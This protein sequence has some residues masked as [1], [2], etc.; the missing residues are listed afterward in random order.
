MSTT[1]HPEGM[2][3]HHHPAP[4]GP[5]PVYVP[6]AMPYYPPPPRRRGF[7]G[8]LFLSLFMLIFIGSLFMNFMMAGLVASFMGEG[9][10][11]E[12]FFSHDAFAKDKVAIIPI[13]GVI[14]ETEDGF[15][16]RAIDAAMKDENVKG[17]VLRVDS[18][19]GSVTGSDF[20]YHHLRKLAEDRN[21]PIVV[22]MGGIAASGGYYVSMAVGDEPNTIFAEPTGWTG[23]IGV[24]MP[25]YDISG[26]LSKYDIVDDS[27]PSHPLKE[28]GSIT[29]PMTAEERKIIKALVDDSFTRFKDVVK[30]G[31][32]KFKKD[33]SALD[34]LAT[35]Q[36][37]TAD[38]AAKNG[39]IDKLGFVEDA[40][41]RAIELARLDKKKVRVV[42]YKPE[43]SLSSMLLGSETR[44]SMGS[45][46][47]ALLDM[48]TPRAY[49]LAA[50]PPTGMK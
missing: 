34:K 2:P 19:G 28:M 3:P 37:Y 8:R 39:L 25:H 1:P 41:D 36:V 47:K 5:M 15:V 45:E 40:V 49:Y 50:W 7:W 16:K 33:P 29:K 6:P 4:P 42:R 31:R 21:I 43:Q 32:P 22:S 12:K 35:G 18:P 13:E 27:V 17:V 10:V 48:T 46:L 44:S 30:D 26:L 24:I 38:Q 23:S 9:R 14:M 20:I 11:Q